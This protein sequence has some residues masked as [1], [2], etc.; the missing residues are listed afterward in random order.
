MPQVKPPVKLQVT[1]VLSA[2][3]LTF[4]AGYV[5]A[6]GYLRLGGIYV[7]NM[8][9]NSVSLGIHFGEGNRAAALGKLLPV[10]CFVGGLVFARI[11]A[12]LA[13]GYGVRRIVSATL[14]I[15]TGLL[16][17][18]MRAGTHTGGVFYAALAMGMQAAT[19]T[20]FG[21]VTIY[22]AFVTGSLV[23]FSENV[24]KT[25]MWRLNQD[26]K[27]EKRALLDSLWFLAVWLAYVAGA[28]SGAPAYTADGVRVILWPSLVLLAIAAIDLFKPYD[29][30]SETRP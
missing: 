8:S 4:V 26:K 17:V 1:Q 21:G 22:T 15:E 12:D 3:I 19:I 28:S 13:T 7:A 2:I 14:A 10:V 5:D 6:I 16:L 25:L 18:F 27:F 30:S 24:A 11:L 29:F 20:R 23:K 9:G